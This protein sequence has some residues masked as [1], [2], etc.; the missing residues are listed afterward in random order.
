MTE[1]ERLLKVLRGGTVDRPPVIAPGGMMTMASKEVMDQTNCRWPSI[2]RD[3][4]KMA[5]LSVAMHDTAG[6]ENLGIPF[7]M[8]VEAEALGGEVEDGD[9]V[10]EPHILH[11]PLKSVEEWRSL[12]ELHPDRD[13]RLPVILAC[14]S[15]LSQGHPDTPVMGNLVGPFSLATSLIDATTLFKALRREPEVVHRMLAFLADNSI[16]YGE[17][18]IS[19]GADLIVISDPSAT[20]EI[21]GPD[22]FREFALPYLSHMIHRMHAL[23]KPVIVH[24]CGKITPVYE[25]LKRLDAEGISVDSMVNIKDLRNAIPGKLLMGNVSTMLLQNGPVN[26]IQ[27]AAKNLLDFGIDI[28]AP[29][30]GLSAKTPVRHI[31]AMTE[32][33]K[34]GRQ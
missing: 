11:Y 7:C 6:I 28:L 25:S 29:A 13:G 18:L 5:E 22:M 12:K 21:L 8:T 23:A 26:K 10:T 15:L 14:T 2:H 16:R 3:A 19:N 27:T 33:A 32:T 9:E 4:G 1:K 17:A 30:C 20:G 24:I 34:A 31:R